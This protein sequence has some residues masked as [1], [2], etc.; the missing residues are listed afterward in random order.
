MKHTLDDDRPHLM[1]RILFGGDSTTT[2]TIV[3]GSSEDIITPVQTGGSEPS[4]KNNELFE[5]KIQR[6]FLILFISILFA[7]MLMQIFNIQSIISKNEEDYAEGVSYIKKWRRVILATFLLIVVIIVLHALFFGLIFVGLYL[8][9]SMAHNG[10]EFEIASQWFY[11]MIWNNGNDNTLLMYY[12]IVSLIILGM[13]VFFIFYT[14]ITKGYIKNMTF[15]KQRDDPEKTPLSK[16]M[17]HLYY[18]A[19]Y[20][21]AMLFFISILIFSFQIW[22]QPFTKIWTIL[23]LITCIFFCINVLRYQMT[24]KWRKYLIHLIIFIIIS[25]LYGLILPVIYQRF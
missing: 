10:N 21:V 4:Y 15:A 1:H 2:T 19:M 24:K 8:Q 3:E 5:I 6:L 9:A 7:L 14:L 18:Y 16:G 13:Y 25:V 22:N 17:S 23:Y 12:V 20:M 11:D